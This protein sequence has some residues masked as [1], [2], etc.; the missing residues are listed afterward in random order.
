MKKGWT[1][2]KRAQQGFTLI[3]LLIVIAII[4]ILALIAIP[5]FLESQTRAKV[6]RARADMR[7]LATGLESYFTDYSVFPPNDYFY[8]NPPSDA[9]SVIPYVLTTPIAYLSTKEMVDPFSQGSQKQIT[10]TG[11]SDIFYTY[12]R[13]EKPATFP[14][15]SALEVARCPLEAIDYYIFTLKYNSG[16]REKY[17][18]WRLVSKGPDRVYNDPARFPPP[19]RGSDVLYDP[20]NGTSSYGNLLRTQKNTAGILQ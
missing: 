6:S 2:M 13:I 11:N 5:N 20:T 14:E 17:G 19:L 10:P 15:A 9:C 18:Y 4:A 12:M 7:T 16:A 8:T 1:A 3:E